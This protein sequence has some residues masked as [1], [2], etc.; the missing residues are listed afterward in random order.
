MLGLVICDDEPW[1]CKLIDDAIDYEGL[2]IR[3]LGTAFDGLSAYAL[4]KKERP[5][6]VITDIR[7]PGIDGIELIR[8]LRADGVD[9]H[10]IILSGYGTF[11]Y[12][13]SAIR[14][15]VEDYLLK[16]ISAEALNAKLS[17]I[18][19][20]IA[21]RDSDQGEFQRLRGELEDKAQK[22]RN[23]TFYS[24]LGGHMQPPPTV[25]S[26]NR[27]YGFKFAEGLFQALI[28]RVLPSQEGTPLA[29]LVDKT[30]AQFRD[31]LAEKCHDIEYLSDQNEIII[32][33]NFP[34]DAHATIEKIAR[35]AF[36]T[37][38]QTHNYSGVA[39]MALL[40]G[41]PV[42]SPGAVAVSFE[43]ARQLKSRPIFGGFGK[44][45]A[46]QEQ[47]APPADMRDI[48]TEAQ[49]AP[50]AEALEK[51]DRQATYSGLYALC[52]GNAAI[53][54][55]S[56]LN[57]EAFVARVFELFGQK[58]QMDIADPAALKAAAEAAARDSANCTSP[59]NLCGMLAETLCRTHARFQQAKAT[60][61]N[62]SIA[63]AMQHIQQNYAENLTVETLAAMVY[64]SPNY[65][66]TAFKKETGLTFNDYLTD[67]R[68]KKAR[69]LLLDHSITIAGV[70]ERV[71]YSDPRYFS[72]IFRKVVGL[73][74][75]E[76]RQLQASSLDLNGGF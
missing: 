15:R 26:L 24:L 5:E 34:A 27:E 42:D 65:F 54:E 64:L 40:Q 16:P 60:Q 56:V 38:Q 19:L 74:P 25:D 39:K 44:G 14:Y 53:L 59:Q 11:E 31:I 18:R 47:P 17:K 68:I 13:Q 21:A 69:E 61:K 51:D 52:A 43:S 20:A 3:L 75:V 28:I 4:I 72:R 12:A 23:H 58:T 55:Q 62:L 73:K 29:S 1:V 46:A 57:L 10:F 50:V 71:G 22:V 37:T 30:G 33:L 8:R 35:H 41:L 32:L 7:M 70:G 36:E 66:C 45:Y 67:V 6:V 76:Y 49:F 48:F 2:G 9:T 63:R